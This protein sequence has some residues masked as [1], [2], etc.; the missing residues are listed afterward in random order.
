MFVPAGLVDPI[1]PDLLRRGRR[2]GAPRPWLGVYL[3]DEDGRVI[4]QDVAP[5]GPAANAGLLP[6]DQ[7]AAISDQPV[8]QVAHAW[9][10]L[11]R[12]GAA[13]VSIQLTVVRDGS[14]RR[15]QADTVDRESMLRK[16]RLQ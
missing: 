5:D 9:R 7:I 2:D 4:V 6:G 8:V 13:G 12:Q 15:V 1:L 14:A 11:W 3:H 16:P 10:V